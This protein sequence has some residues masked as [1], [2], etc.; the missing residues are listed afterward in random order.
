MNKYDSR[1]LAFPRG[2]TKWV[3]DELTRLNNVPYPTPTDV[4]RVQRV[5]RSF[6]VSHDVR[7]FIQHTRRYRGRWHWAG[8]GSHLNLQ[9]GT[10]A[11]T[12]GAELILYF[13]RNDWHS[14][15]PEPAILQITPHYA[16]KGPG[17]I[18]LYGVPDFKGLEA[19][20]VILCVRGRTV[21][22]K[23][24]IYVGISRARAMLIILADETVAKDIPSSFR[25]DHTHD[26]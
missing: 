2:G 8:S 12:W 24:V 14:G 6:A 17:A 4:R 1:G 11:P 26:Q 22:Q 9:S 18:P 15:I 23:D 10:S 25:W 20:I 16:A 5:A 21:S 3:K 7:T 13:E 19:D